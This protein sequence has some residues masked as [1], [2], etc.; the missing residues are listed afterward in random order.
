MVCVGTKLSFLLKSEYVAF[1][2]LCLLKFITSPVGS[3][4]KSAYIYIYIYI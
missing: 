3:D 1:E 4:S 2:K